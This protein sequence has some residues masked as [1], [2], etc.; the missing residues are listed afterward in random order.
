MMNTTNQKIQGIKGEEILVSS[1]I[2]INERVPKIR[3]AEVFLIKDG[4]EEYIGHNIIP[5]SASILLAHLAFNSLS[6]NSGNNGGFTFLAVG[7]GDGSWNPLNPPAPVQ[8]QTQLEDELARKAFSTV[9]FVDSNG[10][11][12]VTPTSV[13]DFVGTF[14]V[15]EAV[16]AWT[17]VGVFGGDASVTANSGI[18][19]SVLTFPVK[20]KLAPETV[21][22]RFRF[23]F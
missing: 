17:E 8:T 21:S 19:V 10:Q 9:N 22:W 6:P 1:H 3:G 18:L 11:P 2:P 15:G 14:G 5:D 16:G 13:V 20:S 7:L 23:L 12:T 4:E